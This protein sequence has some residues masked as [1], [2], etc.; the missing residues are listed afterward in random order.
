MQASVEVPSGI[1]DEPA[2]HPVQR[3]LQ[4]LNGT[5]ITSQPQFL[6]EQPS[7]SPLPPALLP[8]EPAQPAERQ[9]SANRAPL[10]SKS[11]LLQQSAIAAESPQEPAV[12]APGSDQASQHRV[13]P[14]QL[15]PSRQPET[16]Q[17]QS[18]EAAKA[19]TADATATNP[20]VNVGGTAAQHD[21][22]DRQ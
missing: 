15:L 10:L 18:Q 12:A 6:T 4:R 1:A 2:R 16:D 17:Q 19:S 9:Q 13:K 3:G 20:V 14:Q 7:V 21:A 11:E 5:P 22:S 8:A